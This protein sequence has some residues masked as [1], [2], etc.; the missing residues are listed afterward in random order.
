MAKV[1]K[2]SGGNF[3]YMIFCPA[4]KCGHG[5]DLARWTFN[6]DMEKPAV[7]P[8]LLINYEDGKV[9]HSF[10]KEGKIQFLNDCTHDLAGQTVDL[11]DF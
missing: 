6:G 4:C 2:L 9:C 8:S 3:D 11:E 7:S 10:I 1:R 5:I